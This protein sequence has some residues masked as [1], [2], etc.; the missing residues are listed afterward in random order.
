MRAA[1]Y[2]EDTRNLQNGEVT[3]L[4]T[5]SRRRRRRGAVRCNESRVADTSQT[6]TDAARPSFHDT[7]RWKN[8]RPRRRAARRRVATSD[9]RE[10]ACANEPAMSRRIFSNRSL[11]ETPLARTTGL[12]FF[13]ELVCTFGT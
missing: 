5:G 10:G 11:D 12:F 2:R 4:I 6:D 9:G 1:A 8:P 3:P 13:V 7:A